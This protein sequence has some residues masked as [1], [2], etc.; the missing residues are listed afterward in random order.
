[1]DI[2][3]DK[4]SIEELVK[5]ARAGTVVLP[6]F[7]RSF[8]WAY[9]DVQ[10]LLVSILKGYFI[11]TFLVQRCDRDNL[12]FAVRTIEGVELRNEELKPELM[13]LDG[14]Q[15][16]TTLHYV[17]HNPQGV[18][19][20]N[21]KYPYRFFLRLDDVARDEIDE[22]VFGERENDCKKWYTDEWQFKN[23]TV[24]FS[25]L[26]DFSTWD[27]W[28]DRYDEWTRQNDQEAHARYTGGERKKWKQA[29]Q[30][31]HKSMVPVIEIPK[32]EN[33]D[34][35]GIAETCAIFEKMNSTGVDLSVF[36]LL[37]ARLYKDNI[38]LHRLWQDTVD[39]HDAI[40]EL[41]GEEPNPYY[42]IFI[43]R[44]IALMRGVDVKSK[45]I[46]NLSPDKFEE[47]WKVAS[48]YVEKALQRILATGKD[49]FGVFDA[50][51]MPYP[52]MVVVMAKMLHTIDE[53]K[54]DSRAFDAMR[55]WYW[56][57]VFGERYQSAVESTTSRDFNSWVH[58]LE[59]KEDEAPTFREIDSNIVNNPNFTL[60]DVSRVNAK[61]KGIMNLLAKRGA[62]DFR[63]NDSIEFH[64]LD[65]HHIFPKNYLSKIKNEAGERRYKDAKVNVLVNKT[66][67]HK[68]TNRKISNKAPSSYLNDADVI[69]PE[70]RSEILRPHFINQAAEDD[71]LSDDF[72]TFLK[73][74]DAEMVKAVKELL[75]S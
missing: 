59:G 61:Y 30:N 66:L 47:E 52:P 3:P 17:L 20:K 50:K 21:T 45:L 71:M 2:T 26:Q 11:G 4:R 9:N 73:E 64:E 25:V 15:R 32:V 12:P 16:L 38:D 19:L 27:E 8:V 6:Q 68:S 13:V 54:L 44:F 40:R 7:Q 75:Q 1:M 65:D 67:I 60:M 57:S 46:I 10:D 35:K 28:L 39:E 33:G 29:V 14:Q 69:P 51:W 70:Q 74:R 56:G 41:S 62:R 37:T 31:L 18:S 22:A 5:Q 34:E 36:D 55:K 63:L 48:H 72:D 23:R 53:K 43:L 24:P 42:G 58:L 49:G